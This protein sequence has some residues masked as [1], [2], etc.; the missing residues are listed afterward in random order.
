MQPIVV[1][2]PDLL[3]RQQ[4]VSG[5]QAAGYPARGAA[6][7]TRLR[8]ALAAGAGA[9][10]LELD[11]VDIDGPALV[12]ELK[13]DP[14]TASLP[15]LGFCAHTRLELI[16]AAKR[17]GADRVA[18]RGELTRRLATIMAELVGPPPASD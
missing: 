2:V 17:A 10:V 9:V 13:D 16:D 14:A 11:G 12:T 6:S 5:L 7:A 8:D 1:H 15:V 4:L 3:M 18:A